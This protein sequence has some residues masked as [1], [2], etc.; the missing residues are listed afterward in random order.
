MGVCCVPHQ[1][2]CS[3]TGPDTNTNG[4]TEKKSQVKKKKQTAVACSRTSLQHKKTK[5]PFT[6]SFLK[7][8]IKSELLGSDSLSDCLFLDEAIWG[9]SSK[10]QVE[11]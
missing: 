2:V 8:E 11:W 6:R 5:G 9:V 4:P 10:L 7:V 1:P 3:H